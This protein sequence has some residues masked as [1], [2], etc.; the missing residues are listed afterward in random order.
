MS[1][2]SNE[3]PSTQPEQRVFRE[4][5]GS[6]LGNPEVLRK[7]ITQVVGPNVPLPA[8]LSSPTATQR[9]SPNPA[10]STDAKKE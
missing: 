9:P 5:V 3:T 7:V 6:T 4:S 2:D 8:N 10:E 1:E